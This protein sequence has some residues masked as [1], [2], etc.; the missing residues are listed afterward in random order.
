MN[1]V[2]FHCIGEGVAAVVCACDV[3]QSNS[4]MGSIGLPSTVQPQG[5]ASSH[6]DKMHESGILWTGEGGGSNLCCV[7]GESASA[8]QDKMHESRIPSIAARPLLRL[9]SSEY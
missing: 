8:H 2:R 3:I 7:A 9:P 4:S 5:F 6:H 1:N